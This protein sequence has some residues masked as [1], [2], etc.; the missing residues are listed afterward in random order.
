MTGQLP[1][2]FKVTADQFEVV[3]VSFFR[4]SVAARRIGD[5]N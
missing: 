3:L 4:D 2:V 1:H 5:G